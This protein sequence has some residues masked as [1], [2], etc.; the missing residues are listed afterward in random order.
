MF[1]S[2]KRQPFFSFPSA[3]CGGVRLATRSS[4]AHH[5]RALKPNARLLCAWRLSVLR[6]SVFD[7]T[8]NELVPP[9][10]SPTHAHAHK[11]RPQ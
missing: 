4:H 6:V 9:S 2:L 3:C 8:L 11:Q 10:S 1:F 5:T 7:S